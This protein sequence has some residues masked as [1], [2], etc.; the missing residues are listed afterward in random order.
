M[1]CSITSCV[2]N[3][4]EVRTVIMPLACLLSASHLYTWTYIEA[5]LAGI[6]FVVPALFIFEIDNSWRYCTVHDGWNTHNRNLSTKER[7]KDVELIGSSIR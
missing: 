5:T 4:H 7:V 1:T 6:H 3:G 2:M